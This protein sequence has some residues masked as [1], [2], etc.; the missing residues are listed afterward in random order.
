MK[1]LVREKNY[2]IIKKVLMMSK[3]P[4]AGL[5]ALNREN[6]QIEK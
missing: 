1:I 3:T 2:R 5:M 6:E 4:S